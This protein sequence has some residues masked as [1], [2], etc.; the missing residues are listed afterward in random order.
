MT[1]EKINVNEEHL[2]WAFH[3]KERPYLE[4]LATM[5]NRLSALMQAGTAT[6]ED[7]LQ[8]H[9]LKWALKQLGAIEKENLE[10]LNDK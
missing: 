2:K 1:I 3:S 4:T 8:Y 5:A 7:K 10:K 6:K 9:S